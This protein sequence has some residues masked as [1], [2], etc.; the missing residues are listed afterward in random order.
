MESHG[1]DAERLRGRAEQAAGSE[2]AEA[3]VAS[4]AGELERISERLRALAAELDAAPDEERAA[5]LVREA[6]ELASRIGGEVERAM[7]AAATNRGP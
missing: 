2:R 4:G 6:S 5:E 1:S 3:P 7:R